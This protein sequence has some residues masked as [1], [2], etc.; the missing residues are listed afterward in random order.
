MSV[1]LEAF[2]NTLLQAAAVALLAW[3]GLRWV[4]R[5]NAATRAA[6]WWAVLGLVVMLPLLRVL[7]GRDATIRGPA[8]QSAAEAV[9]EPPSPRA[10]RLPAGSGSADFDSARTAGGWQPARKSSPAPVTLRSRSWPGLFF[11]LWFAFAVAQFARLVWSYIHLRHLKRMGCAPAAGIQ[12][13]FDARLSACGIRRPVRLLVSCEVPMP[14]A[15]GFRHPVVLLPEALIANLSTTEIDHVLLHEL[16]HLARYD[17]WTNLLARM[18]GA[19]LALHPVAAW[20][21]RQI[22]REREL[23]CDDWVVAATG[24]PRPYAESLARVFELCISRRPVLLAPGIGDGRSHLGDRIA[25]LLSRGREF[26]AQ[27]SVPRVSACG[28]T[29]LIVV[30]VAARMPNW[31]ALAHAPAP[32]SRSVQTV[33]HSRSNAR[34]V[35]NNVRHPVRLAG[36]RAT[37]PAVPADAYSGPPVCCAQQNSLLAALVAAGYG[38]LS[39]DE[40]INLKVRGITPDF[41]AGMSRTG[42]GKRQ[43]GELI[44]LK[45]QGVRPEYIGDILALGFG[46]FSAP[47]FV[48]FKVRGVPIDLFRALKDSGFPHASAGEILTAHQNGL[49]AEHLREARQYGTKL[50]LQQIVRLKQAG[51]L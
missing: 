32:E 10:A 19:F 15:I 14:V 26:R 24:A 1:I 9:E 38:D 29:M 12:E 7:P 8:I 44:Q 42:W 36:A 21:L 2:L 16:A 28:V 33:Y 46:P 20:V 30:A 5:V 11:A 22:D 37:S 47:Q 4:P 27:A 41:L 13:N 18:S 51:V 40:I 35:V 25:I 6:I 17:D 3:A 43:P 45:T 31:I 34:V 50:T 39:V 48:D 49:R 23:A